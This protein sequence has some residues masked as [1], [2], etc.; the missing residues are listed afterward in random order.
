M[1]CEIPS[2]E[3]C[4]TAL[5][6]YDI[7]AFHSYHFAKVAASKPISGATLHRLRCWDVDNSLQPAS[8]EAAFS[9]LSAMNTCL[10][11]ALIRFNIFLPADIEGRGSRGSLQRLW[12][13]NCAQLPC[14]WRLLPRL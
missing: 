12:T 2:T 9:V 1:T 4:W 11:I 10:L 3:A 14:K 6:R 5:P 13:S 7:D 8:C